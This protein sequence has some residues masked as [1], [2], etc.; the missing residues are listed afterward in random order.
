V[1]PTKTGSHEGYEEPLYNWTPSVAPTEL[2]QLPLGSQWGPWA[3]QIVM[4]TLAEQA[5][6]F[7]ELESPTKVGQVL[8][9]DVGERIR[10]LEVGIDGS[11]IATTDSGKLLIIN[12]E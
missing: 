10:D 6:I 4:G 3:G 12:R 9:L 1:K 5:L 2:V 8:K 7:V 11:L